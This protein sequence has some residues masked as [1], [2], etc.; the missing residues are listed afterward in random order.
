MTGQIMEKVE[1]AVLFVFGWPVILQPAHKIPTSYT[2]NAGPKPH[3]LPLKIFSSFAHN[4]AKNPKE[5]RT[6][7]TTLPMACYSEKSRAV[8]K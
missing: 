6:V 3:V 5:L 8:K 2:G 1:N 7:S 4:T